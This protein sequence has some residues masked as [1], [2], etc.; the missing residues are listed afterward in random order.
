M[1]KPDS[2]DDIAGMCNDNA[3]G[4]NTDHSTYSRASNGSR[5]SRHSNSS[6]SSS[7]GSADNHSLMGYENQPE[8]D[9]DEGEGYY[10]G[11]T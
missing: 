3:A 10:T 7:A 9:D 4:Y 1:R 11:G 2:A 8:P 6:A 5:S